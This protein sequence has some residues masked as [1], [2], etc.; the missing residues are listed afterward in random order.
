[1]FDFITKICYNVGQNCKQQFL[2]TV[3]LNAYWRLI[4]GLFFEKLQ[5]KI[6]FKGF[7]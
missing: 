7:A 1:V 5:E 3:F 2:L 4:I 6:F